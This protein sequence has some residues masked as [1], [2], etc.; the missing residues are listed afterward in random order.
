MLGLNA[1]L[2]QICSHDFDYFVYTSAWVD[3][4]NF[5]YYPVTRRSHL[6]REPHLLSRLGRYDVFMEQIKFFLH[7]TTISCSN[8]QC[9]SVKLKARVYL[10]RKI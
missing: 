3:S 5:C 2:C 8:L 6:Y 7:T 1:N 4:H 9:D 10:N